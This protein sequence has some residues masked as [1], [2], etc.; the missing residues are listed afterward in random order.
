M[1]PLGMV[2]Y[3]ERFGNDD[4]C[5]VTCLNQLL[6]LGSIQGDRFF[7]KHMFASLRGLDRNWN[8]K[9]IRQRVIDRLNVGIGEQLVVA[10]V[11]FLDSKSARNILRSV[12]ITRGDGVDRPRGRACLTAGSASALAPRTARP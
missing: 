3:H 8:V 1:L 9:V 10:S 4:A 2:T 6:C 12:E 5:R 11:S 7:A